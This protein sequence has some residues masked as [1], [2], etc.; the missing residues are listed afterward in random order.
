MYKKPKI[1]QIRNMTT[2]RTNKTINEQ[3]QVRLIPNTNYLITSNGQVINGITGAI[4]KH[5][6]HVNGYPF[7]TIWNEEKQKHVNYYI[8]RLVAFAFCKG[9]TKSKCIVNHKDGIKTNA[10]YINLEFVSRKEN[11]RHYLDNIYSSYRYTRF[12]DKTI[13]LM[14]KRFEE[15]ASISTMMREFNTSNVTI[16]KYKKMYFE[17]KFIQSCKKK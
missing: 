12:D 2:T 5:Q 6:M 17:N 10:N 11:V 13:K 14:G 7:A 16:S 8:H 9:Y 15:K 1:N 3:P 4:R